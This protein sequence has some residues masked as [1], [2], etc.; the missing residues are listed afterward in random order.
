M[1][2][3]GIIRSTGWRPTFSSGHR[4]GDVG[5]PQQGRILMAPSPVVLP[6]SNKVSK[7]NSRWSLT[8]PYPLPLP[9]TPG[10]ATLRPPLGLLPPAQ[11]ELPHTSWRVVFR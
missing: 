2:T 11:S 10:G 8:T 5:S 1:S 4:A 9:S 6:N 3:S 7:P